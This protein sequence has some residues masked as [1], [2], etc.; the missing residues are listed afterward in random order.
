M[1][2]V[3]IAF[4]KASNPDATWKDKLIAWWTH[5]PYSHVEYVYE[6]NGKYIECSAS[7]KDGIVRC[8]PHKYDPIVWD[9]VELYISD[10]NYDIAKQFYES[11]SGKKYDWAGILGF[12]IP[13]FRDRD[14]MWF[15]SETVTNVMKIFG[16]KAFWTIDPSETSPNKLYKLLQKH[17]EYISKN[18]QDKES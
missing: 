11:I 14:D 2:K 17:L 3:I 6:E 7:P 13:V 1:K 5:G 16:Y 8:K 12:I 10:R 4:R 15:C 9:Y 18:K